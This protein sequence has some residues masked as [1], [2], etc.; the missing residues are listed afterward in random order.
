MRQG[1]L[2][3]Q[4]RYERERTLQRRVNVRPGRRGKEGKAGRA[5]NQPGGRGCR[6]AFFPATDNGLEPEG[7]KG[8]SG[9]PKAGCPDR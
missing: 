1:E 5:A 7:N 9:L 3:P 6:A 4:K 2:S 8:V